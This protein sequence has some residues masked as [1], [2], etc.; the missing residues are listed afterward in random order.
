MIQLS[1]DPQGQ[2]PST[3]L[4]LVFTCQRSA[5]ADAGATY[6]GTANH[7]S[8]RRQLLAVI[9]G[10][11]S[12]R[13]ALAWAPRREAPYRAPRTA[14]QSRRFLSR[15]RHWLAPAAVSHDW[16][17]E[18]R[19]CMKQRPHQPPVSRIP[20]R[21]PQATTRALARVSHTRPQPTL[22]RQPMLADV[23]GSAAAFAC[24]LI[25]LIWEVPPRFQERQG[26]RQALHSAPAST[27]LIWL[28]SKQLQ[29]V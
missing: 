2:A 11:P 12:E 26:S 3:L 27:K 1:P 19:I 8:S 21:I 24:R 25:N 10:S 20:S 15:G 28:C 4:F 23:G 22:R 6:K 9:F 13:P 7:P 17:A 29:E 16:E 14:C 18:A 5:S